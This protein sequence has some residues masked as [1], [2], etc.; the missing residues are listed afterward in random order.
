M[1]AEALYILSCDLL[2]SSDRQRAGHNRLAPKVAECW[3]RG[4]SGRLQ[5]VIVSL[6]IASVYNSRRTNTHVRSSLCPSAGKQWIPAGR[7]SSRDCVC[8]LASGRGGRQGTEFHALCLRASPGTSRVLSSD[9]SYCDVAR[10]K[11]AGFVPAAV[12]ATPDSFLAAGLGDDPEQA[13]H[14][15]ALSA[16]TARFLLVSLALQ[17]ARLPMVRTCLD[18]FSYRTG[19]AARRKTFAYDNL[20]RDWT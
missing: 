15:D 8:A 10:T 2:R 3:R 12:A 7:L 17:I 13:A 14:C 20:I 5:T 6:A 18:F 16:P 11:A 9:S 4:G 19:A 1:K